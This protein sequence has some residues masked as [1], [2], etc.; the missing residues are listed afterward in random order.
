M[1]GLRED[2]GGEETSFD[3]EVD[4]LVDSERGQGMMALV[5][6]QKKRRFPGESTRQR[7]GSGCEI[8][9]IEV[10]ERYRSSSGSTKLTGTRRKYRSLMT[11]LDF[12][13]TRCLQQ[14]K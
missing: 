14:W 7:D 10:N 11:A 13:A 6:V 9:V 8:V 4:I 5:V 2:E 3:A 12:S 1:Y